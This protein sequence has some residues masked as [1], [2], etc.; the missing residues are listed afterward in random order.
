M[1]F[2]LLKVLVNIRHQTSSAYQSTITVSGTIHASLGRDSLPMAMFVALLTNTMHFSMDNCHS[3]LYILGRY[4]FQ[5]IQTPIPL[6]SVPLGMTAVIG[7]VSKSHAASV[8]FH[9]LQLPHIVR[10]YLLAGVVSIR[11]AVWD[12]L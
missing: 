11:L 4:R 6:A 3:P 5:K 10:V 1:G 12:S 8:S 7:M 2:Q 9:T